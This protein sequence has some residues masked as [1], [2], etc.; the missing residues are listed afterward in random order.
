[1]TTPLNADE[2]VHVRASAVAA[3]FLLPSDGIE[4]AVARLDKGRPSRKAHTLFG[5]S[6][7]DPIEAEVRS[8][9][10]SQALT[11][12]DVVSV[13][14]T[15][16]TG[17]RATV[18]RLLALDLISK[19]DGKDLLDSKRQRAASEFARLFTADVESK[20]QRVSEAEGDLEVRTEIAHLAIEAYRRRLLDKNALAA[21]AA[22]LHLPDLSER[23][24]LE[25]GE[26]AR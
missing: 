6:A 8:T 14:R 17:Y 9:P 23:K 22:K 3:A 10:G 24:L 15:F 20:P 25:F 4:T 12:H 16:G 7:E 2:L 13:A 11:Y 18:Y 26:A 1:M 5:L 21:L 19:S